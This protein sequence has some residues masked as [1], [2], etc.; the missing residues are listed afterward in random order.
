MQKK[1]VELKTGKLDLVLL[2]DGKLVLGEYIGEKTYKF[3]LIKSLKRAGIT[4]GYIEN[5]LSMIEGGV[6]GQLPVAQAFIEDEPGS[7]S[8]PFEQNFSAEVLKNCV[9][10]GRFENLDLLQSVGKGEKVLS[11][12]SSPQTVLKYPNGNNE[13]LKKLNTQDISYYASVNTKVNEDNKSIISEIDGC[14]SRTVY[15]DV[16]VFQ[17]SKV[18]SIGK[19]HGKIYYESA[20]NVEADIRSESD[21]DTTSN[22]IV[23][24]MIRASKIEAGGNIQCGFGLDNPKKLEIGKVKAGQSLFTSSIR[25]YKVWAGKYVVAKSSIEHSNVQ[26][27][28]TIATPLIK[29]SEIRVG[30][31]LYVHN[32]MDGS[33]IFLGSY[34]VKDTGIENI[35]NYHAQHEKR[36]TDI[37][38][39]I[40]FIKERLLHERANS[41]KQI[42]KLKRISPQMIPKDVFLNKYYINQVNGLKDLGQ[43][44]DQYVKQNSIIT[45]DKLRLSFYEQQFKNDLPVEMIVT[46]TLSAG[47][48]I[49]APNEIL[50]IK[51]TLTR[52]SVKLDEVTGKI[53]VDKIDI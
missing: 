28:H 15:G 30:N 39:E 21:V 23:R 26:C 51:S 22:L 53:S 37:E 38:T 35:L 52:V 5:C 9:K 32:V 1:T 19:A 25:N 33:R 41:I 18:K 42:T 44:I 6:T 2:R 45:Q 31:K 27:L 40:S 14:A 48:I 50:R 16:S 17:L 43:K 24:G 4:N 49:T 46:G 7:V 10:T 36:L 20:L 12:T 34:F 47:T 11:I 29:A 3:E 13:Q 8:F